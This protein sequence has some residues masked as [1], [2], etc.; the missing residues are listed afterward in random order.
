MLKVHFTQRESQ[1]LGEMDKRPMEIYSGRGNWTGGDLA[2]KRGNW[3][4]RLANSFH[5]GGNW[6]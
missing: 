2:K 1:L 3:A 6:M 4:W 5:R